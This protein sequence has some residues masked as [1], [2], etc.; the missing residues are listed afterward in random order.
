MLDT[1]V[2]GN[3]R[4][5]RSVVV[6]NGFINQEP[7]RRLCREVLAVKVDL[8]AFT[9]DFYRDVCRGELKPVLE[10]LRRLVRW[11]VWTEIVV[12]VVPTLNDDPEEVRRMSQWIAEELSPSVPVHFTRFHPAYKIRDLPPTP[13]KSLERCRDI[14]L[15][16]G[17]RFVYIGNVPGH[18]AE[19]TYCPRC[20]R[21]VIGRVGFQI[22]QMEL[23]GGRCST[24]GEEIPGIWS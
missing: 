16:E 15:Q 14:A 6:T 12:L 9:E 5:I 1:A 7:L 20:G 11:G 18:E 19:N 2:E 4:G 24:C 10:T 21:V 13:V 23:R 3:R 8:K 22:I 17:L